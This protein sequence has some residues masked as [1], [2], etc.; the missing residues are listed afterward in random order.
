MAS[1]ELLLS[2]LPSSQPSPYWLLQEKAEGSVEKVPWVLSRPAILSDEVMPAV[3]LLLSSFLWPLRPKVS[4]AFQE[5][6]RANALSCSS[7]LCHLQP[8]LSLLQ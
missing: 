4:G 7:S 1:R 5:G 6:S 2:M 8:L 3:T